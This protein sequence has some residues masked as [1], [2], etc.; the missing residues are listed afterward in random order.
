[1]V[2]KF[3]FYPQQICVPTKFV[4]SSIIV[5]RGTSDSAKLKTSRGPKMAIRMPHVRR[6]EIQVKVQKDISENKDKI[7]K[8]IIF[9]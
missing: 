6:N 1:M 5:S 2:I 9:R 3:R 8:Q 7:A 4:K